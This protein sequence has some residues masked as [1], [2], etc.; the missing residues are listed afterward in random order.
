MEPNLTRTAV[1][2]APPR[3]R[4]VALVATAAAAVVATALPASAA[5]SSSTSTGAWQDVVVTGS[6]ADGA[7]KAVTA[8]GGRV[9]A[10]L[11]VVGGVAAR[12]PRGAVL[13]PEWV[14]APQRELRVASASTAAA[15]GAASTVRE[16]LGLPGDGNEGRGVTVAVVD[17]GIANVPDLAGQVSQHVDLTGA[18]GGDGFGHGTFIAGLIA[19]TGRASGGAYRGVAPAAKLIDVKVADAQGRTDL[20]TVLRGLQWVSEHARGVQVLN[21]SLSSGSALPYQVDPL[22][23]GLEALWRRG[24]TVV[25]PSGNDGPKAGSITSPGNDPVL[26]T[27]GGLDESGTV[28]RA[29]DVVGTWS[30]RGPTWQ[31]DAKPDLVAP[32]AHLVSLRVPGSVVDTSNPQARVGSDYFRGSGTSMATAVTSGVVADAL[33]AQPRLRPDSVKNLFTS[34]AYPAPGLTRA[35]GA[36]AGGLD[37]AR[38]LRSAPAWS[39]SRSEQQHQSDAAAIGRDAKVWAELDKALLNRDGAAA[40]AAWNKLSVASHDWAERS[41][42]QL[43]PATKAWAAKSWSAWSWAGAGSEWVAWSWAARSW[44]AWSWADANWSAWSWADANW[45][46]WSWAGS[47][48]SAW[49]WAGSNWSAWSWASDKWSAQSWAWLPQP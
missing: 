5:V 3:L 6:G 35:A 45:S 46:A 49:S 47:D 22:T 38:I 13:S 28:R 36:G 7:A 12:L 34:T 2:K 19:G 14:V 42:A 27:A 41:W 40:T 37:A 24:I 16:T 8:A 43:D 30:G 18:G 10:P 25:V 48:W 11:P 31:G 20:I 15:G 29:D 9:L 39:A 21:L 4:R 17:T 32:S 44:V 1:G 26:L 33:A 23:Q